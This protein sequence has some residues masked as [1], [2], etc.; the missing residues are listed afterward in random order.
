MEKP[1]LYAIKQ[2]VRII[3]LLAAFALIIGLGICNLS[4]MPEL[5]ANSG[6]GGYG[7]IIWPVW[8][9]VWLFIVGLV[10]SARATWRQFQTAKQVQKNDPPQT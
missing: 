10:F 8:I 6:S 4:M 5:F 7:V 1:A 3:S 9:V 2:G